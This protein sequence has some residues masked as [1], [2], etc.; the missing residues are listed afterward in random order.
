MPDAVRRARLK[1][2]RGPRS[3]APKVPRA[4]HTCLECPAVYMDCDALIMHRLRH[5]EGKHW[6]CPVRSAFQASYLFTLLKTYFPL[7]L[8]WCHSN[9]GKVWNQTF[10]VKDPFS[11]VFLFFISLLDAFYFMKKSKPPLLQCCISEVLHCPGLIVLHC[12]LCS[13]AVR[14]SF[15]WGM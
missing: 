8:M 3:Q 4:S 11:F 5:V 14:L 13:S 1:Q 12:V 15:D 7:N 2:L 6:P 10:I 9:F